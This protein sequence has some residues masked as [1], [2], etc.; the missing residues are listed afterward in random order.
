MGNSR[1][2]NSWIEE[3]REPERRGRGGAGSGKAGWGE[4][5]CGIGEGGSRGS[6]RD[7]GEE[8]ER[9]RGRRELDREKRATGEGL[10]QVDVGGCEYFTLFY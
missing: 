1:I 10:G 6:Q 8:W 2:G 7:A 5:A 3:Q 4:R 9:I